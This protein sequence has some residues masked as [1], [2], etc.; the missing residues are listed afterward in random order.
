[1][2]GLLASWRM[3]LALKTIFPRL[4]GG[5]VL[6]IGCGSYPLFLVHSPFKKKVGLDQ[7]PPKKNL[8]GIEVLQWTLGSTNQL[9]FAD[10]S[11]DC[12]V[13]LAFLEHL[14]PDSLPQLFSEI[15]RVLKPTGQFIATTPHAYA[16]RL[17]RFLAWANLVSKEEIEE[18]KSLFFPE[19]IRQLLL[20]AQFTPE[21]IRVSRFQWG[22][23]LLV[24]AEKGKAA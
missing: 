22:M 12:L 16:D 11:F 10:Q 8:E 23:N 7:N 6:D 5:D 15:F 4:H 17:L 2:E 18:H 9:P 13:S 21:K 19:D 20:G 24:S 1:M 14:E 3:H